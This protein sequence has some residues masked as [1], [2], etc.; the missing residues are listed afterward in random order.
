[1]IK[2]IVAGHII[3]Y[4]KWY[5]GYAQEKKRFICIIMSKKYYM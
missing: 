2:S 3:W 4:D 1:M 5:R